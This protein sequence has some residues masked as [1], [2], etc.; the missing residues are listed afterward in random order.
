[1]NFRAVVAAAVGDDQVRDVG[2]VAEGDLLRCGVDLNGLLYVRHKIRAPVAQ[3]R[4]PVGSHV[5]DQQLDKALF[6][7]QSR[8]SVFG[9]WV[10][11]L[12]VE[13][14]NIT[15]VFDKLLQLLGFDLHLRFAVRMQSFVCRRL[16]V[17]LVLLKKHVHFEFEHLVGLSE[18]DVVREVHSAA[19]RHIPLLFNLEF[20]LLLFV[21]PLNL[22]PVLCCLQL[23]DLAR[24]ASIGLDVLID[25]VLH[26]LRLLFNLHFEASLHFNHKELLQ[27]LPNELRPESMLEQCRI[28][29]KQLICVNRTGDRYLLASI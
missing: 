24:H 22:C 9:S 20:P 10:R 16:A 5:F 4:G 29:D 7:D 15:A 26:V 27:N 17:R 6:V 28:P 14:L 11:G 12:N 25:N 3:Q 18:S 8:D 23:I 13:S 1:V 19:T 21:V 2:V